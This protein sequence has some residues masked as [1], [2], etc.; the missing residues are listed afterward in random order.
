[1][2]K[3]LLSIIAGALSVSVASAQCTPDPAYAGESFGL[4]P[5]SLA[6]VFTCVGCGDQTRVVDLVTFADTSLPNPIT[7]TGAD[8]VVYI[9]AFKIVDVRNIPAGMS[10]GTNIPAS[11]PSVDPVD[12]PWGIWYNGGTVPNQTLTQG[13][14]YIT[15]SESQW[16]DV[17]AL[18]NLPGGEG[19][20][21][22]EID[23]DARI[24]GTVPSLA[25]ILS[26]GDWL[27]GVPSN[28]GGGVITVSD[29]WLV[30][31][32]SGVGIVEVDESKFMLVNNYVDAVTG[33]TSIS[34][35]APYNMEG[36]EFNVYSILG[37]KIHSEK[38]NVERGVNTVKFNGTRHAA[39][40][41]VYTITDGK[42][43]LTNK[44]YTN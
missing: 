42:T 28:L 12:A 37:S 16:N 29:Y 38:L 5:D 41:Y 17:A 24:G 15:G 8:I 27:S 1:M 19:A 33:I 14:V 11:D 6:T 7:P 18:A 4:F 30:A 40:I 26:P 25:P 2:K 23:V 34:F 39:G 10:Y 32:T 44:M 43:M 13:C 21:Q 20:V 36:L 22:L 3:T 31:K 9:D 35:N